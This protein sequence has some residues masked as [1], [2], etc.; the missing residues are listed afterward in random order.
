MSN[1]EQDLIKELMRLTGRGEEEAKAFLDK[2]THKI[3]AEAAV[4]RAANDENFSRDDYPRYLPADVVLKYT[5]RITLKGITRPSGV[6]SKC[7]RTYPSVI[8]RN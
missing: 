2:I 5:I 3:M 7:H 6:R 4:E 1:P 8:C